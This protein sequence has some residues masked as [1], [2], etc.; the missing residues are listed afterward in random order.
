MEL[1][2]QLSYILESLFLNLEAQSRKGNFD[3][4][5]NI[6]SKMIFMI[7]QLKEKT[8]PPPHRDRILGIEPHV[9]NNLGIIHMKVGNDEE[10]VRCFQ[11]YLD[12]SKSLGQ[13]TAIANAKMNLV[14]AKRKLAN[15]QDV[16]SSEKMLE[17]SKTV[18]EKFRGKTLLMPYAMA[19]CMHLN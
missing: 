14:L 16:I 2:K 9:Y 17:S 18:Y 10:S 3:T 19:L 15:G 7:N 1:Y 6:G 8:P 12:F 13:S 5:L 4:T 11:K